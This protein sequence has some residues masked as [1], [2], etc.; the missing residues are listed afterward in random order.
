MKTAVPTASGGE[1]FIER[2]FDAPRDLVFQAWINPERLI[3]WYAPHGC[4]TIF[5]TFEPRPGGTFHSCIRSSEG[6]E[7]W[8]LG[9][10]KEI[11]PPER[12]VYTLAIADANGNL[13]SPTDV[14]MDPDW[15]AET[16]L[17]VTFADLNG[18]THLTLRQT[19]NETLARKTGAHPSWLQMLDRL[20][21]L[22][23]HR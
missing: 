13:V 6:H 23:V 7:C 10:F 3:R 19:V 20:N 18:R 21:E 11:A 2:D 12:L 4:T 15:P 8:C 1:V 5:R 22:L 16:A 17:T 9:T 14:G